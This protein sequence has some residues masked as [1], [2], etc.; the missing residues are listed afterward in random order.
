[1][2]LFPW[3]PAMMLAFEGSNIIDLGL[4]KI[5]RVGRSSQ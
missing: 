5:A 3:Y 1:V 2:I 4:W